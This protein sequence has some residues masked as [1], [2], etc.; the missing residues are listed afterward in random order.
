MSNWRNCVTVTQLL[1]IPDFGPQKQGRREGRQSCQEHGQVVLVPAFPP[2]HEDLGANR[3][4]SFVCYR[5]T[6]RCPLSTQSRC[7]NLPSIRRSGYQLGCTIA[8]VSAQWPVEHVKNALQN[9]TTEGTKHHVMPSGRG[10]RPL[11][12]IYNLY[13][14]SLV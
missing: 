4:S 10:W 8:A 14:L 3:L 7:F 5:Y 11:F 1:A 6:V 13:L 2:C 9:I 12:T